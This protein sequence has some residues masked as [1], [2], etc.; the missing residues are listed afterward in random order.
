M[1]WAK[2]RL[3]HPRSQGW[4]G[5]ARSQVIFIYMYL[6]ISWGQSSCVLNALDSTGPAWRS[7]RSKRCRAS[8]FFAWVS[9]VDREVEP[10]KEGAFVTCHCVSGSCHLLTCHMS[11][12]G[13]FLGILPIIYYIYI[14]LVPSSFQSRDTGAGHPSGFALAPHSHPSP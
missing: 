5:I 8:R 9:W 13:I 1:G 10:A 6:C 7:S 12:S 4:V 14:Y 3:F 2:R 11:L